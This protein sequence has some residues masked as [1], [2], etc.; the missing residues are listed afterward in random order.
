MR[1][2][3][4]S[5]GFPPYRSGGLT[6]FCMDIMQEEK[7][8]G[9]DVAL[10]WPGK[11]MLLSKNVAVEQ[12]KSYQGIQ[13]W[14]II[15][16]LPISY[17]EGI[18]DT[19]A[20][21]AS[22]DKSVFS[23]FLKEIVP[24]V[25]HIHTLMGLHSEFVDVAKES[26]IKMVFS[27][28]DFFT[29]CPKVT[30]YRKGAI[31]EYVNTCMECPKCNL[32]ALSMKK[33]MIL[34]SPLYRKLK[35]SFILKKIR[36]KHRDQYLSGNANDKAEYQKKA[37]MNVEDYRKLRTYYGSMILQMD[38][39][40]YNSTITKKVFEKFFSPANSKVIP[41]SHGD[42][43]DRRKIKLF[44]EILR[45]TY[46]GPQSGGKGFFCLKKVLDELWT[47]RHDFCLNVFF[48]P[49]ELSPYMKTHDRYTYA[50]LEWIF[51]QTDA[52]IV[53]SIWYETFGYTVLEALSFGVPVIV[54]GNVGAKDIIPTGG[55]IILED[56]NPDT[57]KYTINRLSKEILS[58][59][60]LVLFHKAK[61]ITLT[62]MTEQIIKEC[63]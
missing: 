56:M 43:M 58:D 3:H 42:I 25:I 49:S 31:C 48:T 62:E 15:N 40:H 53:P 50:D 23:R 47:D 22:C 39:V 26:G 2:L 41:I 60:N 24:D 1:I 35:D 61:I 57:L 17:D 29:V 38:V 59:M 8:K 46:L 9:Y 20:F 11:L 21:M 5:L 36:K 4:Y 13:S 34:Q 37:L 44:G 7:Q 10:L 54:S 63:Y 28:H 16:P 18:I 6:K 45:L 30:M 12:R 27:V 33:I 14:E 19:K 32:T 51:E 55:G 52:L